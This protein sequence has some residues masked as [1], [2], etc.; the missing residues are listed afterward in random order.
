MFRSFFVKF[1]VSLCWTVLGVDNFMNQLSK[2]SE[3]CTV[4]KCFI[5]VALISPPVITYIIDCFIRKKVA[6][7][8]RDSLQRCLYYTI[9]LSTIPYTVLACTIEA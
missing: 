9:L 3:F 6:F 2:V 7:H 1:T 8:A 5:P 4:V